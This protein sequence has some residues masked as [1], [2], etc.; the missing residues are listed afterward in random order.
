[1]TYD[2]W[3]TESPEDERDRMEAMGSR[4]YVARE[5]DP[6]RL[7]DEAWDRKWEKESDD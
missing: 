3:R 1:M 2:L 7:R 6:Y 4:R 5:R